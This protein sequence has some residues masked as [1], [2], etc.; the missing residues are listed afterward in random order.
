MN[1]QFEWIN[2]TPKKSIT[3]TGYNKIITTKGEGILP[4]C[5]DN[6]HS[7]R[8]QQSQVI[9]DIII[10]SNNMYR[11]SHQLVKMKVL[12]VPGTSLETQTKIIQRGPLEIDSNLTPTVF[13]KPRPQLKCVLEKSTFKVWLSLK[14]KFVF[15]NKPKMVW[16]VTMVTICKPI[17][18]YGSFY[19]KSWSQ[20]I[21]VCVLQVLPGVDKNGP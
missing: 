15:K 5:G 6:N 2:V 9:T 16:F 10:K 11:L 8:R 13:L 4:I 1:W 12:Q 7:Y 21:I 3:V 19:N 14:G 18:V 17:T 20:P